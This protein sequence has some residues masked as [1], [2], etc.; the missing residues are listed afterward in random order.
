M[1]SSPISEEFL[2]QA[3]RDKRV[4]E[5]ELA[6][7]RLA[8]SQLKSKDIAQQL[9]ISEAATRKRLGEVYRKFG[10]KGRGPGKLINL[11][12]HLLEKHSKQVEASAVFPATPSTEARTGKNASLGQTL[13]PRRLGSEPSMPDA[14]RTGDFSNT[15]AL[16][17]GTRYQWNDAPAL[18][19]FQGRSQPLHDLAH[20]VLQPTSYPKLLAICG[21]GGIGKTY[22]AHKLTENIGNHFHKVVWLSVQP[23]HTPIDLLK[24]LLSALGNHQRNAHFNKNSSSPLLIRQIM[25]LL[26]EQ[27]C[28][29][30]LD[31][32]ETVFKSYQETRQV[33][34]Q[35]KPSHNEAKNTDSD[36]TAPP[37]T[38]RALTSHANQHQQASA[39]KEGFEDYRQLINALIA[40]QQASPTKPSPTKSSQLTSSAPNSCLILTSREKPRELLSTEDDNP[41]A[42]LYTL[43]GLYDN[44]AKQLLSSFHLQGSNEDYT[45]LIARYYGHP[46]ALRLAASTAKDMFFGRIR[47]FLDQEI[48]VFDDL[49]GVIKE[50]FKRLPPIEEEVMY[51]LAINHQP[52]SLEDLK[53]DI[54]ATDHKRNLIYTLKSL[55]RRFLVEGKASDVTLFRLHPIIEEYVLDRFIRAIFQDLVRGSL[56]LFNSHA[57]MKA[58]TEEELREFQRQQVVK[59]ILN[60]L[61]N[62]HK[63]LYRVE[64]ALNERLNQFREDH[65]HRLGY[66]GGNFI[67]LLVQ[68]SKRKQLS[69]KDFSKMTI[70]QADLQGVQLREISFNRCELDRSVFTETLSDVM[71]IALSQPALHQPMGDASTDNPAATALPPMLA[72]GDANGVVH[73]WETQGLGNHHHSKGLKIA[74]WSAHGSWVRA[75]AFIPNHPL[76]VTGSDDNTLRLWQLPTHNKK[77][78]GTQPMQV[79]QRPARDWVHAVAVNPDGSIIA[80]GGDDCVTLRYTHTGQSFRCFCDLPACEQSS[81][82]APSLQVSS[83]QHPSHR[84]RIRTL[85]FSPDGKWLASCGEDLIIRLWNTQSLYKDNHTNNKS[86]VQ[87]ELQLLGHTALV[88]TLQFSPDSQQLISGSED[89][90]IRVWDIG[91]GRC[92]KQLERH[93]DCVRSLAIS[94]DG[95][96]LASGGDDRQVILW[97]LATF[98][99]LQ[100]ISTQQSRIWSVAFQQQAGQLLLSAGGDK[101]RL[102][103]WKVTPSN[104]VRPVKTYRGYTNGIRTV[105][106]LGKD[107]IIGGGDG[108]ELSVWDRGGKRKANLSLHQGR[109]WSVAVDAQHARIASASDDHTIRLWDAMTGQCLTT[110][111]GHRNWVRAVAFSHRGG[112]LASGGDDC[113]IHIWNTASG[114]CLNTLKNTHWVRTIAFDPNNSRYL[115]SGGDDAIVKLWDRKEGVVR[116]ALAHHDHRICSVA[117]SP[118]GQKIASAS[119]DATVMVYDI[120]N[121][122]IIHQFTEAD[123]GLKSVAFSPD[124]RYLA[125]GGDDQLVYVWDLQ[126]ES[127]TNSLIVLRPQDYTGIAGGIRAVAFSPDSRLV[128]S[129]GL[130]EMIRVGNLDQ[131]ENQMNNKWQ[132]VM[133]PLM[134]RDRPYEK[135]EIEEVKGLSNLQVA[136]LMTLG[137]ISRKNAPLM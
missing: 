105:A 15:S 95:K 72:C 113:N 7:L 17:G 69:K 48:S 55:Q 122:A 49:R 38:T 39:Y 88:N 43:D 25:R 130:D 68:L 32:Y 99:P 76:L 54:V 85:A 94:H 58:D 114:F 42:K 21:I 5:G 137:A 91:L 65:P 53:R 102:M 41:C 67:N 107:R 136:N 121:A 52:C 51:W 124:G 126:T 80:S 64:Q 123:L 26:D 75:I 16:G 63:S 12:Q 60:R 132:H 125:A 93:R 96:F 44:E 46:M 74:E 62:Y 56:D 9:N 90:H 110:L 111:V 33:L 29:I 24:T 23:T 104:H 22:L 78:I 57:L 1:E 128:I 37:D 83:L 30:V 119:D 129:G 11:K 97:D 50:Q 82:Q 4:S 28:L 101:Q 120:N 73:L 59:P 115:I 135:I 112:V 118:D 92:I 70:W 36:N 127:P 20:W 109:I 13:S 34:R 79:W 18:N 108:G 103:M 61:K 2:T 77:S 116:Q 66:A 19:L 133:T 100:D 71:A 89:T 84:N 35:G 47:D 106:F 31:G 98:Q 6:A 8:L 14:Q 81:L 134:G 131:I 87:S 10:I 40:P 27:H 117:Y 3:A 45:A 86:P